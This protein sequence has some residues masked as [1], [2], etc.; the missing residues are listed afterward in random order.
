MPF[1]RVQAGQRALSRSCTH[2][3]CQNG[4]NLGK[5]NVS[6]EG[7]KDMIAERGEPHGP[8]EVGGI[9][10]QQKKKTQDTG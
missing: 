6:G 10:Q 4:E 7:K 1:I 5:N 2:L 9:L 3:W 8:F